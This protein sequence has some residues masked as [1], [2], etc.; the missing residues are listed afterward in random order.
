MPVPGVSPAGGPDDKLR[1]PIPAYLR[2]G[3]TSISTGRMPTGAVPRNRR[4]RP[5]ARDRRLPRLPRAG[6]PLADTLSIYEVGVLIIGCRNGSNGPP[7]VRPWPVDPETARRLVEL[8]RGRTDRAGEDS[9]A[10]GVDS[11]DLPSSSSAAR[12]RNNK[13]K[14][15]RLPQRPE[16]GP[17][18]RSPLEEMSSIIEGTSPRSRTGLAAATIHRSSSRPVRARRAARTSAEDPEPGRGATV[19]PSEPTVPPNSAPSLADSIPSQIGDCRIVR[20][21]GRG[22]MGVVYLGQHIHLDRPVAI[23]VLPGVMFNRPDSLDRLVARRGLGRSCGT[24]TSARSSTPARKG[25]SFTSSWSMSR[26]SRC[27]RT[28]P[29]GSATDPHRLRL[30]PPTLPGP[31]VPGPEKHCSPRHQAEQPDRRLRRPPEAAG[32]R[33]GQVDRRARGHARSDP[34]APGDGYSGL[35]G[36]R[37]VLRRQ[38]RLGLPPISTPPAPRSSRC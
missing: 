12:Q 10:D 5:A 17:F 20:Q 34:T 18:G 37:A 33:P 27:S 14:P 30:R 11:A 23:K 28:H 15:R 29:R 24:R 3:P 25:A 35:H 9:G 22:G 26:G 36:P 21:I 13:G 19:A 32:P 16:F 7:T 8:L 38:E 6:A 4:R 2:P 31:E 1:R